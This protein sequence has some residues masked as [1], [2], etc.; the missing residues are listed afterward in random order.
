MTARPRGAA[1]AGP[2][3]VDREDL[4][5]RVQALYEQ[6]ALHPDSGFH[7]ETGRALAEQL[8]YPVTD[9]DAVPAEAVESFAGVGYAFD[10]AQLSAGEAVLDLGSGAGTDAFVAARHV[11][12]TGRVVGVDMTEAQLAKSERLRREAGLEQVSFVSGRIEELPLPDD[13]VDVVISNGVINLAPDKARV[14]AEAARVLRPGGRMALSD[15]VTADPLTDAIVGDVELWASCIGGAPQRQD[16]QQ[17]VTAAGLTVEVV[18]VNPYQ[19]L[20]DQARGASRTYGVQ[21]I[22]LRARAPEQG[23]GG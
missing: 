16:Y 22:S 14:F 21:S 15:I 17:L 4:T 2:A 20:S 9:L 13:S 7:F 8:G 12:P 11:G 10:L 5:Q 1:P 23:G 3:P 6:V 18:K 19:F